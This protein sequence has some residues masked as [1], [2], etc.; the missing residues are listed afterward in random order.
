MTLLVRDWEA[1]VEG[2]LEDR[3]PS[4][5]EENAL[6]RYLDHFGIQEQDADRNGPDQR[7]QDGRHSGTV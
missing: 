2:V 7:S 3:L 1:T 5:G 6:A 4:F